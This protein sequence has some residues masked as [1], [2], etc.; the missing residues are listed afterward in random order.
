M[1]CD[2]CSVTQP[3]IAFEYPAA[4]FQIHVG[5]INDLPVGMNSA[6]SWLACRECSEM[7]ER[8][9]LRQLAL[10][11]LEIRADLPDDA[12]LQMELIGLMVQSYMRFQSLRTGPRRE[13]QPA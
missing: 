2:F 11:N 9:E 12:E 8:G 1:G 13:L 3:L 6:G 7:I 5:N 4:D 10:R